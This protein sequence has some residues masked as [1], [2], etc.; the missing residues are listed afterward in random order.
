MSVSLLP[1]H[2]RVGQVPPLLFHPALFHHA[3][4]RRRHPLHFLL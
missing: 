1:W 4:S 3:G 2:C